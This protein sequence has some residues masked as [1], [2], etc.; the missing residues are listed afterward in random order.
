M[1][2]S[3]GN[4][5]GGLL[6]EPYEIKTRGDVN[7]ARVLPLPRGLNSGVA[8]A[9][10]KGQDLGMDVA[11]KQRKAAP[12]ESEQPQGGFDYVRRRNEMMKK[13]STRGGR[14]SSVRRA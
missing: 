7:R 2:G 12:A 8:N 3:K 5:T 10:R 4:V 14:R 11:R 13:I 9:Q 6:D 1:A